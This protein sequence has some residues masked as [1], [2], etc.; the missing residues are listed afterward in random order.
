MT[1]MHR[2]L[3]KHWYRGA[4]LRVSKRFVLFFYFVSVVPFVYCFTAKSGSGSAG[5]VSLSAT[6]TAHQLSQFISII[7][8]YCWVARVNINLM[9]PR[10]LKSTT[11]TTD[12][13]LLNLSNGLMWLPVCDFGDGLTWS[14]ILLFFHPVAGSM[15][16]TDWRLMIEGL[17][18]CPPR[19][20][21]RLGRMETGTASTMTFFLC[22]FGSVPA[23]FPSCGH[24]GIK[25]CAIHDSTP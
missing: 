6:G 7:L 10:R 18:H 12:Y 23:I 5:C 24:N 13:H 17:R 1:G 20:V 22:A 25:S 19:R 14:R 9:S 8:N 16:I 4:H 3:H 11:C 21:D 2:S 15:K